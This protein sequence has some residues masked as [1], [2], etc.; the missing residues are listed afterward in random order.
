MCAQVLVRNMHVTHSTPPVLSL[1]PSISQTLGG[2]A[3]SDHVCFQLAALLE[4]QL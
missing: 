3:I 2:Y 4:V 1:V